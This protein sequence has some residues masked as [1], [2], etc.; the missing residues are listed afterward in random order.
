MRFPRSLRLGAPRKNTDNTSLERGVG[1]RTALGRGPSV[2][3]KQKVVSPQ[4]AEA[5][6]FQFSVVQDWGRR[7]Q[8]GL[9]APRTDPWSQ[10][11]SAGENAADFRA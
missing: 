6:G 9:G 10:T 5:L 7:A 8:H 11:R 2:R 4:R 1:L 3:Q